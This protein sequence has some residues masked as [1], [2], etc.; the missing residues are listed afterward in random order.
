MKLSIAM[1]VKNEERIIERTLKAIRQLDGKITY[2]III[3]DTGSTDSTLDI[4]KKYAHRVYQHEWTGNFG[5]MRNKTIKY[6]KGDWILILDADEV[7]EDPEEII[8]FFKR[9][10]DKKYTS[11]EIN[12]KNF[13][14]DNEDEYFLGTLYRLFKNH[15]DFCYVGRIHE[16]PKVYPPVGKSRITV[17]HYGYSREDYEVMRYKYERNKELLLIDIANNVEPLYSRFQLAQTYS[18][19]NEN[20]KALEIIK[21]AYDMCNKNDEG[22]LTYIKVNIYHFYVKELLSGGAF[23][24]AIEI[25]NK[26]IKDYKEGLDFYYVLGC[27]YSSLNKHKE[28]YDN[29]NEYIKLRK[30]REKGFTPEITLIEFSYC[31]KDEVIRNM[32]IC[33]F[34]QEKYKKTIELYENN[35]H[36]K[37]IELL[38][39]IYIYS[40]ALCD[41]YGK[42]K[43]FYKNGV[44]EDSVERIHNILIKINLNF[45]DKNIK[46]IG[47][48]LIGLDEKLDMYINCCILNKKTKSIKIDMNTFFIWKAECLKEQLINNEFSLDELV[49]SDKNTYEKY[50]SYLIK[51]YECLK[52][53]YEYSREHFLSTEIKK[54]SYICTIEKILLSSNSIEKKKYASLL[55]RTR[56]NNQL[57]A[58]KIYLQEII[59]RE[60]NYKYMNKY[61]VLWCQ[62][63]K[64]IKNNNLNKLNYIRNYKKLLEDIPEYNEV[65]D[66]YRKEVTSEPLTDKMIE[67]K[68]NLL[69][70]IEGYIQNNKLEEAIGIIDEL[71]KMFIYDKKLYEDKGI[72]LFFK[73]ELIDALENMAIGYIQEDNKFESAYNI[74]SCLEKMG[75]NIDAKYFYNVALDYC[76]NDEDKKTIKNILSEMA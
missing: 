43:K 63:N 23:E 54:C 49:D 73:G 7:L 18:M 50:I 62:I 38:E 55:D 71:N 17:L 4:A 42:I 47:K 8:N 56:I 11:V 1:M 24:K 39:E 26:I 72:A 32:I 41:E 37:G 68:N 13:V 15:K 46:T 3:V 27:A 28:A 16:Q 22:K 44:K 60:D 2:E 34:K 6:C 14:S 36:I 52:I 33:L 5:E 70:T 10:D 74:A 58:E 61:V 12:F 67:E 57:L 53:I 29:F 9:G 21:E 66:H 64:N 59:D 75:R 48:E 40:L 20:E 35:K 30:K 51:N 31:R 76:D 45:P 65:I 69:N 19:A 25:A